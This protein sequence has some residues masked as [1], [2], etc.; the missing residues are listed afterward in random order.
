MLGSTLPVLTILTAL[1]A[2][3]GLIA[4][5]SS[6]PATARAVA[7]VAAVVALVISLFVWFSLGSDG[8]MKFV[9]RS[10]W[11]PSLGIEYHLGV[12]GLGALMLVLS[13]IVTLMAIAASRKITQQPGLYFALILLL[14]SGLFGTFTALNFFH[15]FLFWELSL[16][17]A[18]FLIKL[19]G[20]EGRGRAATTFFVYTMVGSVG[21]LL[22]FLALFSATGS[23]DFERLAQMAASGELATAIQTHLGPVSLW[24]AI[25][26]LLGFAV[27]VPLMPFHTWLPATYA[28]APTPVT[29]LLTGAM[30]K[31]GVYGL[32]RLALPIFGQQLAQIRTPLLLLA[33]LTVVAGAWAAV[34]QKD[35]KRIFAYS[36]IN[37][38]GYCLLAIFAVA[39]PSSGSSA[40]V[41]T[42]TA[43]LDGVILQMFNHGLTAATIFW[44]LAMLEERSNGQLGIDHF[45]G[46][47]KPAPV[48]CGL[49]GIALFSSLGLP[50]LNGF[51]S[52]F[53]I[54]RGVFPLSWL[55]ATVS[56]LGLLITAAVILTVIQRVFTGP[57][58]ERWIAFP[59]LSTSERF[60]LAPALVL[61]A[62]LGLAP[63]LLVGTINATVMHLLA[64]WR[65]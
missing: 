22:A 36:S 5:V 9:E 57:L 62:V 2:V 64:G 30:S 28:K 60:A 3:A 61:M 21:L 59:D 65:L 33:T 12:D 53:L 24:L 4:L 40:L 34:V 6:R 19:W 11:V 38:L 14:E 27:K 43:A 18:F 13:S 10:S 15:W 55:S 44:F 54:F 63:Q 16:I 46:L 35:L 42:Q 17:P 58:P 31:M 1:P 45:G 26:V 25:G 51:V 7:L 41:L 50:S 29:M 47:R 32:L 39:I 48:L 20:G 8:T 37:H 23:M 52:E 56:V 49:M